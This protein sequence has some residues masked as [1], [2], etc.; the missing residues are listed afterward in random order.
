MRAIILAAGRGERMRPLTDHTPKPMLEINGK[1]LIRY[2]LENLVR[3]GV[4]EIVINHGWQGEQ[5]EEYLG[6]GARFHATIQ[7]SAEGENPLETGGGIFRVLPLLG[8]P[9]I[10]LNADIWTDYPFQQ[11]PDDPRGVAHLVLVINPAHH[12][13]GDFA[14]KNGALFNQGATKFTYS[15]IG[16]Y[17]PALF[18]GQAGGVFPL[19]PLIRRATESGLVSGEIYTGEWL[20]IGTPARLQDLKQRF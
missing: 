5:I 4:S 20:D 6:D 12:P 17:R 13:D 16:V 10:V 2:H 7:Y 8:D 18:Q 14:C 1:P 19:T 3:S 11:L 15:G 9:F